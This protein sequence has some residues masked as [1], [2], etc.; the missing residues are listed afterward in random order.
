M[1]ELVQL[2]L[3]E[4]DFQLFTDVQNLLNDTVGK[5]EHLLAKSSIRTFLAI[6]SNKQRRKL[7]AHADSSR[8]IVAIVFARI[9]EAKER[10][11]VSFRKFL[12]VRKL[13]NAVVTGEDNR[14]DEVLVLTIAEMV[15]DTSDE[16]SRGF[17]AKRVQIMSV[18]LDEKIICLVFNNNNHLFLVVATQEPSK[19]SG[20]HKDVCQVLVIPQSPSKMLEIY[21]LHCEIGH[22]LSE[23]DR[24]VFA[25]TVLQRGKEGKSRA[26]DLSQIE[27]PLGSITGL[28][29]T[30]LAMQFLNKGMCS[31]GLFDGVEA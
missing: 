11:I 24:K 19:G 22:G 26:I 15:Q 1:A 30:D 25:Q 4:V 21:V 17:F 18:A 27:G 31:A 23:R 12:H 8:P 7:E 20:R 16:D 5:F 3:S 6:S 29:G 14:S 9:H 2:H 10:N 28:L 13:R